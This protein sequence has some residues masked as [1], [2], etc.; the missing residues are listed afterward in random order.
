MWVLWILAV[1]VVVVVVI[2]VV[3]FGYGCGF[4]EF[5]YNGSGGG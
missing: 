4:H 1:V 2:V 3:D 5:G